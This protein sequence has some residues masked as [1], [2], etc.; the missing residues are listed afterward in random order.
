MMWLRQAVGYGEPEQPRVSPIENNPVGWSSIYPPQVVTNPDPNVSPVVPKATMTPQAL[1]GALLAGKRNQPVTGA[2]LPAL[3]QKANTAVD[4]GM[5]VAG[6]TQPLDPK[7]VWQLA[8]ALSQKY[9]GVK[10]S[11]Q[12]ERDGG[13][14][15]SQLVVPKDMRGQGVGTQIMQEI[16]QYADENG[17]RVG[18]TPSDAWGGNVKRLGQFYSRLGFEPNRGRLRDFT[19]KESM[20]RGPRK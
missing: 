17:A 14:T 11:L 8:D 7:G 18:L 12:P 5:A 19:T 20:L 6:A 9:P 1:W 3:E 13:M 2:E 15:L 4:Y 16:L 10:V